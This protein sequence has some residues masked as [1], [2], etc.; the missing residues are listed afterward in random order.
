MV[1]GAQDPQTIQD[2]QFRW[3]VAGDRSAALKDSNRNLATI[4]KD[5]VL[6]R[7]PAAC[8]GW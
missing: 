2:L 8:R 5:G 7:S 6:G 1:C 3:V 4:A